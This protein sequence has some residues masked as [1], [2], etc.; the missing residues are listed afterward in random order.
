MKGQR[1]LVIDLDPQAHLTIHLGA[2]DDLEAAGI[3]DVLM[4]GVSIKD[5]A[6]S[7]QLT[8]ISIL[9]S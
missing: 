3:Y 9:L 8:M 6:Q 4:G 1:V 7:I 5:A 2:D